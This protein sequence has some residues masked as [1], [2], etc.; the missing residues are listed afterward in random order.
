M[1][2]VSRSAAGVRTSDDVGNRRAVRAH[3]LGRRPRGRSAAI[4]ADERPV[5]ARLRPRRINT[6]RAFPMSL[7]L[8]P[9]SA[10]AGAAERRAPAGSR[11]V[12]RGR[13]QAV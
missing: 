10:N 1:L 9:E 13:S 6:P 12:G 4:R 2:E 5:V 3:P 7:A 8:P 11:G